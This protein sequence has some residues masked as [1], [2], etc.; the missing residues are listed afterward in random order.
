MGTEPAHPV[1]LRAVTFRA[2]YSRGQQLM[3]LPKDGGKPRESLGGDPN[4]Y[5]SA[6]NMMF[7]SVTYDD[8][9]ASSRSDDTIRWLTTCRGSMRGRA[10]VPQAS[11]A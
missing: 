3:C 5:T 9:S 1:I 7:S 4:W 2:A 6:R 8:L 10:R 11:S